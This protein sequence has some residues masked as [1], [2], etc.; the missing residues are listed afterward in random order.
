MD[1]IETNRI[2]PGDLVLHRVEVYQVVVGGCDTC[3]M[4]NRKE[5]RCKGYCFRWPDM[6]GLCF[7]YMG[8]EFSFPD[9][10]KAYVSVDVFTPYIAAMMKEKNYNYVRKNN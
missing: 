7:K 4:M 2:A 3:D 5:R 6:A 9:D 1:T 10:A 8:D